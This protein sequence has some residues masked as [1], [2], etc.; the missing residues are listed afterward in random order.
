[1]CGVYL[2]AVFASLR[3]TKYS[4]AECNQWY[5]P[6]THSW[7]LQSNEKDCEPLCHFGKMAKT[8]IWSRIRN[9]NSRVCFPRKPFCDAWD[10]R[11]T[12]RKMFIYKYNC[13]ENGDYNIGLVA[14][15]I[16]YSHRVFRQV[17]DS[18]FGSN[19]KLQLNSIMGTKKHR[20]HFPHLLISSK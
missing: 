4:R 13:I 5:R 17:R 18:P 11:T 9:G 20:N 12:G 1:M 15:L 3:V 7:P 16:H 6:N 19:H 2:C 8:D 10:E 14:P